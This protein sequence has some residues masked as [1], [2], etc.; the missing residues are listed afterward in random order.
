MINNAFRR[1]P[2]GGNVQLRAS[3]KKNKLTIEVIDSGEVFST[4]EKTALSE[5]FNPD[6]VDRLKFPQLAISLEICRSILEL[7]NSKLE[8]ETTT[9]G[10][11]CFKFSLPITREEK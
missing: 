2:K 4:K 9:D 11:T 6:T 1:I 3:V 7:H 8:L 10:K 5:Q